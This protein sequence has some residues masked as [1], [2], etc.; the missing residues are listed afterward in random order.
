MLSKLADM[1]SG[2]RGPTPPV[3]T[4]AASLI[5]ASIAAPPASIPLAPDGPPASGVGLAGEPASQADVT[6]SAA[7]APST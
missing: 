4:G 1:A 6:A 2:Q 7:S 5:V 3:M